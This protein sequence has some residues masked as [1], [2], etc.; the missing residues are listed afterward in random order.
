MS[1]K[2]FAYELM[3][4]YLLKGQITSSSGYTPTATARY[5]DL[6]HFIYELCAQYV[7]V[8]EPS[9][10]PHDQYW[11]E[12]EAVVDTSNKD[13]HA[14]GWY[15]RVTRIDSTHSGYIPTTDTSPIPGKTYYSGAVTAD[16]EVNTG[17]NYYKVSV[18]NNDSGYYLYYSNSYI[19]LESVSGPL[20]AMGLYETNGR[21]Y[22]NSDNYEGYSSVPIFHRPTN[23]YE[24]STSTEGLLGFYKSSETDVYTYSTYSTGTKYKKVVEGLLSG[25]EVAPDGQFAFKY[26]ET[27]N[28]LVITNIGNIVFD[29]AVYSWGEVD[30]IRIRTNDSPDVVT[31]YEGDLD[32]SN[33]Y[34]PIYSNTLTSTFKQHN[35][36]KDLGFYVKNGNSYEKT[37]DITFSRD[38]YYA[39]RYPVVDQ[40]SR[41]KFPAGSITITLSAEDR[42]SD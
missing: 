18:A 40:D 26:D 37:T 31:L 14:L 38:L 17:H 27:T 22:L 42:F 39:K 30:C 21:E 11:Y 16:T 5:L 32:L 7:K 34:E 23:L 19:P 2:K 35:N 1:L 29:D 33:E 28:K 6:G 25:D 9:G 20:Y 36:P 15:E 13:P 24:V 41:P 10:N 4:T 12:F 3:G 8:A